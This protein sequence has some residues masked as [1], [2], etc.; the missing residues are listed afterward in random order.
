MAYLRGSKGTIT[1]RT[2]DSPVFTT[3]A[4]GTPSAGVMTNM[5]GAVEASFADNAVT[6]AKM[7]GGTD[8][9][10]I[11]YDASGDPVAIATGSDG[12]VL[13]STGAGSPPAFEAA[14]GGSGGLTYT[15]QW[16]QNANVADEQNPVT[17]NWEQADAPVGFGV[18]GTSFDAPS[19]GVFTFPATGYWYIQVAWSMFL[20]SGETDRYGSVALHT[21]HD[22]STFAEASF[23]ANGLG[24]NSSGNNYAHVR[25]NYIFDVTNTTTHKCQIVTD[26]INAN[27]TSNGATASQRSGITFTWIGST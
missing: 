5:T 15:S 27:V 13:T 7:A 1:G 22:N 17:G 2:M 21:T 12:H 25:L 14:A 23:S 19:S 3:P 18:L 24:N 16:R 6:L 20:A 4:V 26:V 9:N 8:G 11:S 10:I